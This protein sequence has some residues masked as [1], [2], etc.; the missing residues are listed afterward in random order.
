MNETELKAL[1]RD[2]PGVASAVKWD[3]DLCFTVAG[4]MFAVYCLH[5]PHRGRI[6]FKVDAERFLELTDQPGIVPAAY[7]ARAFWVSIA[8]PD[9]FARAKIAEFVRRSYE[10]VRA[11]LSKRLQAGLDAAQAANSKS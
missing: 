7:M 5:G 4:K 1:S 9:R 6:S 10:L 11:G 3:D 8:E 2:W